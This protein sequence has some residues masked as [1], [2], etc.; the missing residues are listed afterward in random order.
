MA[1]E[2]YPT[3]TRHEAKINGRSVFLHV[4]HLDIGDLFV[5]EHEDCGLGLVDDYMGRNEEK[6]EAIYRRAV[7]RIVNG[8]PD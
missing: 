4:A 2:I 1:R 3:K 7:K 6:A 5:V 8:N